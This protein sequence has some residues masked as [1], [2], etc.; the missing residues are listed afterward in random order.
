LADSRPA[1]RCE[2]LIGTTKTHAAR[3]AAV[4]AAVF[5]LLADKMNDLV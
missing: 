4:S 2:S 5:K 3:S 1:D